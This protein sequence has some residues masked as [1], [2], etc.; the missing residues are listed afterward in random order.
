[1]YFTTYKGSEFTGIS[2]IILQGCAR[3]SFEPTTG[4][5]DMALSAL[6]GL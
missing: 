3:W 2:Q 1:M 4:H 5:A 6:G